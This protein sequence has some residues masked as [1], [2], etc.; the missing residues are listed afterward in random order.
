MSA[1]VRQLLQDKNQP[2][3]IAVSPDCTVFQALQ[4]LAEH[5][6]GAVAV[7]D[8]PR[9]V[10]IFSERDYARRM[11]LEGRQSSGTP[12]TAVMTER[13]IVVHPDTPA[14]QCMAIMTDNRIRHLPVADNGRVIG[15]V[16]IG[17]VVRSTLAEQQIAIDSLT[18]YVM[19]CST[20]GCR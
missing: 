14:S 15:M 5:D 13:V 18:Q 17:D 12:V 6:I 8:G 11:I 16:S 9:L 7:M 4:K 10:G 2:P 1:T 20:M 3:L 19:G